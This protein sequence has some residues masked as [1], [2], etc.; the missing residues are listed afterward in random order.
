[1]DTMELQLPS[2]FVDAERDEMEYVNGGGGT[3]ETTYGTVCFH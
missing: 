3:L 2:N 1:M